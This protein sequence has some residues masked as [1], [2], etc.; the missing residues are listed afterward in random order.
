M[1]RTMFRARLLL[2]AGLF[3]LVWLMAHH[4]AR[5]D[6]HPESEVWNYRISAGDTLI[7]ISEQYLERPE[8]WPRLQQLNGIGN[9]RRLQ[10]DSV[11]RIPLA[12]MKRTSTVANVIFV[13]GVASLVRADAWGA[14]SIRPLAIGDTVQARDTIRTAV[15]ASVSL[16]LADKSRVLITPGSELRIV[17]LL[18]L[19]RAAIPK[20]ELQIDSGSAE[21]EVAPAVPGR[22]FDIRTPAV[23]L[24]V[25]G[26]D[27]RAHFDPTG[28]VARVEVREGRVAARADQQELSIPGGFGTIAE[29]GRPIEPPRALIA[30]PVL[31][32]LPPRIE[33]LPLRLSW[34]AVAGAKAYRAQVFSRDDP[35]GLLLDGEFTDSAARWPEL[36]DGGYQL[37]VRAI[38]SRGNEG[39]DATTAFEL[40]ARPEAPFT[41]GPVDGS[42]VYGDSTRFEWAKVFDARRYRLQVA[43]DADFS[44]L[45][46]DD[47]AIE[48]TSRTVKLAP[49]AYHWRVASI[50]VGPDGRD[51]P[52]P[53]GDPQSFTQREIPATPKLQPAEPGPDGVRLRWQAPSAGQKMQFQVARD[54]EFGQI[55]IDETTT[56]SSGL[57][58]KP[59]PGSYFMRA[60]AIDA[61]GFQ[62]PFGAVQQIDVPKPPPPLW[63]LLLPLGLLLLL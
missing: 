36:A 23:N 35:P 6:S 59:E 11:L 41:S 30:A 24:G 54:P 57:L 43:R 52:G 20:V 1:T 58:P 18:Q 13:K 31:P 62:G 47:A 50:A 48:S 25:R 34:P 40:K 14:Q 33:R 56:Q 39:H 37:R 22:A 32:P 10:P 60:R 21:I 8:D 38:D 51:D 63:L 55:V 42:K 61:D 5:A 26:T 16:R 17:N 28:K 53:F 2:V 12:W 9:E 15:D 4:A 27:F 46:L 49:G 45:V 19:G 7:G 44:A 29:T 3:A